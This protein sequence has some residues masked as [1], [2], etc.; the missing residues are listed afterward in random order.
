MLTKQMVQLIKTYTIGCVATVRPDGA[1][2]V[3]PK[4]TFL[5]LDDHTIAFA[6]I[7]SPGTV[8]NLRWRSEVEVNFLDVF[9]R[10][11]CRVR[12]AGSYIP[13]DETKSDLRALFKDQWPDLYELIQG[14][15][16]IKVTEAEILSSP[17][18]DVGAVAD[19]LTEQ[20]LRRYAAA[21]GFAVTKKTG[22]DPFEVS[23]RRTG[24]R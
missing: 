11:G 2:A 10:I 7:R 4:A 3:S 19:Q 18:Y 17:S 24:H 13:G 21:L 12:G 16:I 20:W 5:V 23:S 1:P 9:A 15:V 8:E 6:N 22:G 14:V